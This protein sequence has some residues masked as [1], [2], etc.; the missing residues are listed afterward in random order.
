MSLQTERYYSETDHEFG[1]PAIYEVMEQPATA[2]EVTAKM[3]DYLLQKALQNP[4]EVIQA[5]QR[6]DRLVNRTATARAEYEIRHV[7]I[8]GRAVVVALQSLK[9]KEASSL[10][11]QIETSRQRVGDPLGKQPLKSLVDGKPMHRTIESSLL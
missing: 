2:E 1:V 8:F 4:T 10:V 3:T 5:G 6:I 11:K 7:D 9:T